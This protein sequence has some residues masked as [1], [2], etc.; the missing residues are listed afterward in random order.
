MID[1][2]NPENKEIIVQETGPLT[3]FFTGRKLLTMGYIGKFDPD[4]LLK[5]K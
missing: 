1:K 5:T 4:W 2:H 3:S